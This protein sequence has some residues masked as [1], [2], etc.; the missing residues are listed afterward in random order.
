M[1][2]KIAFIGLSQ[3]TLSLTLPVILC[4]KDYDVC[5]VISEFYLENAREIINLHSV[6]IYNYIDSDCFESVDMIFVSAY[7]KHLKDILKKLRRL[8]FQGKI[9]VDTPVIEISILGLMRFMLNPLYKDIECLEILPFSQIFN[10]LYQD[11]NFEKSN[12]AYVI[13]FNSFFN[14]H[15]I[16]L[17]RKILR[18]KSNSEVVYYKNKENT[19]ATLKNLSLSSNFG[20]VHYYNSSMKSKKK[21]FFALLLDEE[22]VVFRKGAAINIS[23]VQNF[24]NDLNLIASHKKIKYRFIDYHDDR[25]QALNRFLSNLEK[26]GKVYSAYD[27]CYD[28]YLDLISKF[29]HTFIRYI[30]FK[31]GNI[32]F[33]YLIY[34]NDRRTKKNLF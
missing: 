18:L 15:G 30:F 5:T 26:Y 16:A 10:K 28:I 20:M 11:E 8:N 33:K 25:Q 21:H 3:R 24:I 12:K 6:K 19:M 4:N 22:C 31:I 27:N 9:I 34:R 14:Y 2:K 17:A 7:P 23:F 1:K 32:F 13:N 29:R